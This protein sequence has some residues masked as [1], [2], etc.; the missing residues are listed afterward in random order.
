MKVFPWTFQHLF[1]F[2]IFTIVLAGMLLFSPTVA[3]AH[4]GRLNKCGCHKVHRYDP[5]KCHCHRA[6]YGGCGPECYAPK[7]GAEQTSVSSQCSIADDHGERSQAAP[8][9]K[10]E[11]W[12]KKSAQRPKS[13]ILPSPVQRT[14][15]Q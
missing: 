4:G 2:L 6:P 12:S 14:L 11:V 5:P 3:L 7:S 1:V 8:K 15:A 10:P 9:N 13:A